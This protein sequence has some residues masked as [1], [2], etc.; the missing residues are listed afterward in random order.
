LANLL[1]VGILLNISSQIKR[2]VR[3]VGKPEMKKTQDEGG[4]PGVSKQ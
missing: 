1:A 2:V 3:V 4:G